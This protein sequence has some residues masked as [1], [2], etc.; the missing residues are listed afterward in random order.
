V[1]DDKFSQFFYLQLTLTPN[2]FKQTPTPEK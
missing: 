1:P 2:L